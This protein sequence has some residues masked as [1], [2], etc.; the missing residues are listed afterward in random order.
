MEP[1]WNHNGAKIRPKAFPGGSGSGPENDV[2]I[3][4]KNK[5][6]REPK[7][8]PNGKQNPTKI[9][10]GRGPEAEVPPQGSPRRPKGP[11]VT[12]IDQQMCQK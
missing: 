1:K 5:A 7:W 3:E 11:K 8:S 6:K 9:D 10:S 12:K 2:K 4:P